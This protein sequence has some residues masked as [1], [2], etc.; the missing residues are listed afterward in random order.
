MYPLAY[1]SVAVVVCSSRYV[2]AMV[3][4]PSPSD[5]AN[6]YVSDCATAVSEK[7]LERPS[8]SGDAAALTNTEPAVAMLNVRV[9]PEPLRDAPLT[10]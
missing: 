9:A 4:C 7:V 8:G 10:V 6:A 2:F 1:E 3:L 5:Q